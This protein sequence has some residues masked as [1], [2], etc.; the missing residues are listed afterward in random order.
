LVQ[1]GRE[2]A[3]AVQIKNVF[4]SIVCQSPKEI[5][6]SSNSRA[7][8]LSW[9]FVQVAQVKR[10]MFFGMLFVSAE[11]TDR[12]PMKSDILFVY[13]TPKRTLVGYC[14]HDASREKR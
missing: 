1:W 7:T 3:I 9:Y 13:W 11:A 2:C 4:L 10:G 8:I 14:K 6:A 12:S 5:T